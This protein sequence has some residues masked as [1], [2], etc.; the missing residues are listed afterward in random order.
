MNRI[1]PFAEAALR[2]GFDDAHAAPGDTDEA[3]L[4]H[5][6]FVPHHYEPNYAYPLIVWL[7]GACG[8]Q[9][10]LKS[11]M[12]SVSLRNYVSVAPQGTLCQQLAGGQVGYNWMQSVQH[13][14]AASAAIA[15]AIETA[16]Q[17]FHI[18]PQRV[19]L[20]G[21]GAGGTMALRVAL[22]RPE[23][24]AGALSLGG[25][26]PS[27]YSPLGRLNELRRLP[28]FLASALQS[29]VYPPAQVC[30]DLRL[31]HAA[32]LCVTLRQYPCGD[33]LTTHMLADMNRWIMEQVCPSSAS[34]P[35]AH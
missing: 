6:F 16:A 2:A 22:N 19:F 25:P 27:R 20:A 5:A 33:A 35:T 10:Q 1:Q 18:A 29:E 15:H 7:H 31:F 4:E 23:Q 28:L 30:H 34:C 13:I 9:Q 8:S 24:F 14:E 17:R 12:P 21:S 3:A 32:G 11:I 26:F